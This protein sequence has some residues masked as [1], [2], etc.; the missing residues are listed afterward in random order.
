[1]YMYTEG[2]LFRHWTTLVYQSSLDNFN[3]SEYHLL[4]LFRESF[5][6]TDVL[7]E[8]LMQVGYIF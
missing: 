1:M 6:R 4:E 7:K 5:T 3:Y 2:V 8:H